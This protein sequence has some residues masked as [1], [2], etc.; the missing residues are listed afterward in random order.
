M[1]TAVAA[2]AQRHSGHPIHRLAVRPATGAPSPAVVTGSNGRDQPTTTGSIA[3][4]V[5]TSGVATSGVLGTAA[6][7]ITSTLPG[8]TQGHGPTRPAPQKKATTA[9]TTTLAPDPGPTTVI[10]QMYGTMKVTSTLV[11]PAPTPPGQICPCNPITGEPLGGSGRPGADIT[12]H[13][14]DYAGNPIPNICV[15][16]AY[17]TEPVANVKT[18]ATGTWHY[19]FPGLGS[20]PMLWLTYSE[21][22]ATN[23]GWAFPETFFTNYAF[24]SG[25]TFTIDAQVQHA[26]AL[27]GVLVDGAGAP[28]PNAPVAV[29]GAVPT[30]SFYQTAVTDTT[31]HFSFSHIPPSTVSV[32]VASPMLGSPAPYFAH[33]S[34]SVNLA[35]GETKTVIVVTT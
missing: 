16:L 9:T 2:G 4:V 5:A 20:H 22:P 24:N 12:G 19:K 28:M 17:V 18:D 1:I 10:S 15:E 23:P 13:V 26:A 31:G 35:P 29:G 33:G 6:R 27:K 30:G 11:G 34:L 3:P 25:I 21:C 8:G 14:T 32:G 7:G